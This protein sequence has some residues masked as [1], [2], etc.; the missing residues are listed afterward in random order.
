MGTSHSG[1]SKTRRSISHRPSR[2]T[3]AAAPISTDD[4]N[5]PPKADKDCIRAGEEGAATA[6]ADWDIIGFRGMG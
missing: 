1:T 2:K 3:T 5:E 6:L 4:R